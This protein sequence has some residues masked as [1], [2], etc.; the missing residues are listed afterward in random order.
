[1]SFCKMFICFSW[2]SS[3][4]ELPLDFQLEKFLKQKPAED[5]QAS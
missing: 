4:F 3:F 5:L 2:D 1:M